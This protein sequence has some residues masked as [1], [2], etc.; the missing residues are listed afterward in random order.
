MSGARAVSYP[1]PTM[2]H[3]RSTLALLLSLTAAAL[4][5]HARRAILPPTQA[6][7]RD[8]TWELTS[9]PS[10]ARITMA[11]RG[12]F[13]LWLLARNIGRRT[14]DTQR[15]QL[16]W[17]I[18]GEA[19]MSLSMAFGNGVRDPRWSGLPAGT[20]VR[21]ARAMGETLFPRAGR[22]AITANQGGREVAR[23]VVTVR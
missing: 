8:I 15:D 16:Q 20:S 21:E 22:Y 7:S 5:A 12:R 4:P 23:L 19:S 6:A 3:R 9:E 2:I 13:R 18:N 11:Q 17:F 14:V 1:S 10:S